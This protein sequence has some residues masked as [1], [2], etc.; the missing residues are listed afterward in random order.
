LTIFFLSLQ[1]T[2]FSIAKMIGITVAALAVIAA[3]TNA[4]WTKDS[5]K[6]GVY[7]GDSYTDTGRGMV[8]TKPA[9]WKEPAVS[10]MHLTSNEAGLVYGTEQIFLRK[11]VAVD[12]ELYEGPRRKAV[13]Y[14]STG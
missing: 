1:T 3:T 2:F 5:F 13:I 6:H 4:A 10:H 14:H 7:F 12:R 9:G 8:G 11:L